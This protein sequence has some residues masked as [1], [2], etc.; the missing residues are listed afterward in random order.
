VKVWVNE[1]PSWLDVANTSGFYSIATNLATW[2][3]T[4]KKRGYYP[5][6]SASLIVSDAN[7]VTQNIQMVK[8]P[9]GTISGTVYKSGGGVQKDAVM[10]ANDGVSA[11]TQANASGVFTIPFVAAGT[12]TL[13]AFYGANYAEKT[14]AVA[15]WGTTVVAIT[16]GS[17]NRTLGVISGTVKK[18]STLLSGIIVTAD[19]YETMTNGSGQYYLA[20]PADDYGLEAN[21]DGLNTAY[22]EY[23]DDNEIS[24]AAAQDVTQNLTVNATGKISGKVTTNGTEALPGVIVVASLLGDEVDAAISDSQGNYTLTVPEAVD[25]YVVAPVLDT[26]ESC[27]PTSITEVIS[28]G[29]T[30]TNKNF[31]VSTVS[32]KIQGTVTVSGKAVTT[33]V[34]ILASTTP[35]ANPANP[36]DIDSTFSTGSTIYYGTTTEGDGTYTLYVRRGQVY[37]LYAWYSTVHGTTCTTTYKTLTN[38]SMT[39]TGS[40]TGQDFA[41]P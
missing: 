11:G 23:D 39:A 35:M 2:T 34:L 37:H 32:G 38:V 28:A 3:V 1:D 17:G 16:L 9:T 4:A 36:P 15:P 24:V 40:L 6:T 12:C 33:G 20:V 29:E 21:P 41:F 5:V 27:S 10:I 19:E 8:I 30:A 18:G 13:M 31:T 22:D 14:V 7:P 26:K 25:G